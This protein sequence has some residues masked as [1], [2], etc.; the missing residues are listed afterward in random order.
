MWMQDLRA[1]QRTVLN[2]VRVAMHRAFAPH[3][4]NSENCRASLIMQGCIS[5]LTPC[6][7][8]VSPKC[9]KMRRLRDLFV[10]VSISI[11][12]GST[13]ED[14]VFSAAPEPL[15]CAESVLGFALGLFGVSPVC[16]CC[17]CASFAARCF[18]CSSL[19]S[20][21]DIDFWLG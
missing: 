11:A 17:F 18:S 8:F 15:L 13:P 21:L 2:A 12:D 20:A 16:G 9:E 4:L 3:I 6:P 14:W 5:P 1:I 19:R 10:A 7:C